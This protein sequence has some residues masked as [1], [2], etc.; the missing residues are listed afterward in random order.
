MGMPAVVESV[1]EREVWTVDDVWAL[2][3]RQGYRYEVL[4]GELLVTPPTANAHQ[5]PA[6]E[7]TAVL[8]LWTREHPEFAVRSPGGVYISPTSWLE[9]DIAV[10]PAPRHSTASWIEL[11]PPVL[12]VEV[13]SPSTRKRD[14][15]HKRPAYLAH[16]VGEVWVV[17]HERRQVERWTA[18]SE[19]PVVITDRIEWSPSAGV[20]P[21]VFEL[22]ELFGASV[23]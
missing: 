6:T 15:H 12:V 22:T 4:H 19:F 5:G 17:D 23:E 16:G 11:P 1:P 2:P 21:L 3:R 20:E 7:L 8:A 18:A 10:Y 14:R 9:P 13:L